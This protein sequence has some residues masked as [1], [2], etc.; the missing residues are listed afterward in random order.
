MAA[1]R[2]AIELSDL[3]RVYRGAAGEVR[4]LCGVQLRIDAGEFVAITGASGS[5]KSTLLSV[6]GGLDREFEGRVRVDGVDLVGASDRTLSVFRN[7]SIGFVFQQ[8]HLL[9][10]LTVLE[11][12]LLPSAFGPHR[13]AARAAELLERLGVA[14]KSRERPMRLSG[15]QQQRVA[16]ARALL[17]R[18]PILLCDEPTGSLDRAN[19]DA[20]LELLLRLNHEDKT[21][22]V[23]VT[24]DPH[25]RA[26]AR[27]EVVL[28]DGRVVRDQVPSIDGAT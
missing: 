17:C 23:V 3:T 26:V 14:D 25:T 20:V 28:A 22:I 16:I 1:T 2:G 18:P 27:R 8:F 12:V 6:M 19:G 11:N 7:R 24:H 21:T 4:A 13:D 10:H 5:G 15:G 9:P